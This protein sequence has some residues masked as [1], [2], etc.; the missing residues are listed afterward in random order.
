MQFWHG[1]NVHTRDAR[2]TAA[3]VVA[4]EITILLQVA[5]TQS[6]QSRQ[7]TRSAHTALLLTT[8]VVDDG[9][10][11]IP[12]EDALHTQKNRKERKNKSLRL[13]VMIAG[14]S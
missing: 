5:L 1:I 10:A 13:S 6:M 4:N 8:L 9:N 2:R 7:H 12:E 11:N 14:A 3:V